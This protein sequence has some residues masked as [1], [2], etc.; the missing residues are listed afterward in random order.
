MIKSVRGFT[1]IELLVVISIIAI[2]SVVGVTVFTGVQKGTRDARRRA[3]INAIVNAMEAHKG[4]ARIGSSGDSFT[5]G[6]YVAL[7][8]SFFA[9]GIPI[10]PRNGSTSCGSGGGKPCV[11]CDRSSTASQGGGDPGAGNC[12]VNVG[13]QG[14][15]GD[16]SAMSYRGYN[17]YNFGYYT[18]GSWPVYRVCTNLESGNPDYYCKSNVQ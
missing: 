3:D 10:D 15:V 7:R 17:E 11:Y 13:S 2:L 9:S 18:W 6:E 14:V 16:P 8:D 12:T 5:Q 4:D 1:L